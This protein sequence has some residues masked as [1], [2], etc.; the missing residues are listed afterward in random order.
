MRLIFFGSG[1]FGLST[2]RS[3]AGKHEV[4]RVVSQPDRPAGRARRSRPTPISD[5][6]LEADLPLL[7]LEDINAERSA[8]DLR[9]IDADAWVVIAFGQ[10]FSQSLLQDR[11]AINL[12]ASLLPRW[13]GAAPIH[14][15]VLAGDVETGVSVITLADRMDAGEVLAAA[16]LPI[17]PSDTTGMLHERL[18]ELGPGVLEEV[19]QAHRAGCVRPQPQDESLATPAPKLTRAQARIDPSMPPDALRTTINGC[20]PWPGVTACIGGHTLRLLQADS[21]G[22]EQAPATVSRE[23]VIGCSGGAVLL[24]EVQPGGGR[25]MPFEAWARGRRLEWPVAFEDTHPS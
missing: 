16:S 12:H 19:L 15:A 8:A 22:A 21:C 5:H 20:A 14:H 2:L 10:K 6:A 17:T 11:F 9:A 3:L 24:L 4:L 25:A 7:R 18:A 23:G 1:S 13:R